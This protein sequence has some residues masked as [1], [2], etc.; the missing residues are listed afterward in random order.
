MSLRLL[1]A[2][3]STAMTLLVTGGSF[4][5][6]QDG[7][8][9][10]EDIDILMQDPAKLSALKL[11]FQT[12]RDSND[13][14]NNLR[15][16][17]NIHGAVPPEMSTGPCTH[18]EEGIWAWHRSYL[19]QFENALRNSHPPETSQVTLPYWNWVAP[20]SGQRY[21]KAYEDT[22][23]S[24]FWSRRITTP[25]AQP[26]VPPDSETSL[27]SIPGWRV[28]GGVPDNESPGKGQMEATVHDTV[29]GFVGKDMAS[30]STS[31]RDPIFWAHHANLDRIWLEWY[32]KWHQPPSEPT[33]LLPGVPGTQGDWVDVSMKYTY[34]PPAA[35]AP[36]VF[37]S[38]R[39]VAPEAL[40]PLLQTE[41]ALRLPATQERVLLKITDI[42]YPKDIGPFFCARV[43]LVPANMRTEGKERGFARSH[44]L[45]YFTD[46]ITSHHH[47]TD[48]GA[49]KKT[50]ITIDV[51][52]RARAIQAAAG[53]MPLALSF[54]L[55]SQDDSGKKIPLKFGP[56][57]V[58]F[59]ATLEVVSIERGEMKSIQALHT[60][61]R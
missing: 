50:A 61:V 21:P 26:P 18:K 41:Q 35:Q 30:P 33:L 55:T 5:I 54:E 43:Y 1:F 22:G 57:G 8:R 9:V 49:A 60:K 29:H 25:Q 34:G 32:A 38:H 23:S 15:F 36:F 48:Q 10:R 39:A 44:Y 56:N 11:A 52:D 53:E 24:L 12:L 19:W 37:D 20:P 51:T 14:M 2:R 58:S 40:K 59:R 7:I 47:G 6:A 3:W 28:F 46:W 13:P 4:G 16:W 17:A 45:A 31:A 42:E 27:L